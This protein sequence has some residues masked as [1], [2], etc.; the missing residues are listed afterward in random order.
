M[1]GVQTCALPICIAQTTIPHDKLGRTSAFIATLIHIFTPLGY[2]IA[3]PLANWIGIKALFI[4]TG[5]LGL[6]IVIVIGFTSNISEIDYLSNGN[7]SN[8]TPTHTPIPNAPSSTT[9][10]TSSNP[11]SAPS[12]PSSVPSSAPSSASVMTLD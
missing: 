1:T 8:S 9:T 10:G 12:S 4:S 3:G 5:G 7:R 6:I 2:L 11:P